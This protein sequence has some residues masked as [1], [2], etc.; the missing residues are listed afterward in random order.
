LIIYYSN[1]PLLLQLKSNAILR[2]RKKDL[3]AKDIVQIMFES[4]L[5]VNENHPH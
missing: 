5:V 4:K 3:D 2:V 1:H